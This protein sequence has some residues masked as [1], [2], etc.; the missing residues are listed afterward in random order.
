M[1]PSTVRVVEPVIVD[2]DAHDDNANKEKKRKA[3]ILLG[4]ILATLFIMSSLLITWEHHDYYNKATQKDAIAADTLLRSSIA[5]ND[6]ATDNNI[7][8]D[9]TRDDVCKAYLMQFLN[10]T[11]DARDECEG[12]LNAYEAADCTDYNSGGGNSFFPADNDD[13]RTDDDDVLIDD[14]YEAWECCSSIYKYYTTHCHEPELASFQ[15][16][17]IVFVLVLCGLVKR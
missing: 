2:N 15:L 17:G 13:N 5:A 1:V 9:A 11:T 12:M 16:L 10:G 8:D 14:A 7:D 6:D 3:W 4:L